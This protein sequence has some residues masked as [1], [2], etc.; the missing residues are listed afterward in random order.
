MN[1][2]M[3][4]TILYALDLS[5]T[6]KIYLEGSVT[7]QMQGKQNGNTMNLRGTGTAKFNIVT[8]YNRIAG[9]PVAPPVESSKP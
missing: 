1:M 7:M 3:T 4:G 5:R 8:V 2:N 9:K 6:L